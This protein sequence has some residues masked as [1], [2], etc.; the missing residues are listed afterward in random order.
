MLAGLRVC[1]CVCVSVC[2]CVCVRV[3]VCVFWVGF[4]LFCE[5]EL[6]QVS[7]PVTVTH[8]KLLT[9]FLILLN[10]PRDGFWC[11]IF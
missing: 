5:F 4:L 3:C 1:V 9:L 7:P 6:S 2:L 11:A 8:N 10:S